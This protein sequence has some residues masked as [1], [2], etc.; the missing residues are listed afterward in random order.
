MPIYDELYQTIDPIVGDN[1]NSRLS[2]RNGTL[3]KGACRCVSSVSNFKSA[4]K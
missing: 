1:D 4:Y 3:N 2:P